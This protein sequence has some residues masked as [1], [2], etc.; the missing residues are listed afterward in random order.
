MGDVKPCY[1]RLAMVIG[2]E[3]LQILNRSSVAVVGIGGE[4][5]PKS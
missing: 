2:S 4:L 3:A 5:T 1:E